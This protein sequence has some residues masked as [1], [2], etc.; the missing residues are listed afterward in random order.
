MCNVAGLHNAL[1]VAELRSNLHSFCKF[2]IW[3]LSFW[4]PRTY[5]TY[6]MSPFSKFQNNTHPGRLHIKLKCQVEISPPEKISYLVPLVSNMF[7]I[8]LTNTKLENRD[9]MGYGEKTKFSHFPYS[10][11][12]SSQTCFCSEVG[13]C[14]VLSG[15]VQSAGL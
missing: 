8:S 3:L 6:C 5:G 11:E 4:G 13:N 9:M 15:N 2:Q 7:H 12:T 14:L 1:L 10:P